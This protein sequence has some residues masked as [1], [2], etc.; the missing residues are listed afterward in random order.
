MSTDKAK[1]AALLDSPSHLFHRASQCA[2]DVFSAEVGKSEFDITPRQL[3]VLIAIDGNPNATQTALV[4][5]TGVDRST[6]AD[7]MR[8]LVRKGWAQRR[9]TKTDARAYAVNLTASG[10]QVLER[11]VPALSKLDRALLDPLPTS[12][13][14][15]FLKSLIT[16]VNSMSKSDTEVTE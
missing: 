14:K 6:L 16:I 11:G 10:R 13:R 12:D 5:A 4:N 15:T 3:A 7:I 9:R 8:R 2:G 1:A